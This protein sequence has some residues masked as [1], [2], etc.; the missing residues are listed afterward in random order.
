MRIANRFLLVGGLLATHA[1]GCS[2]ADDTLDA[3]ALD[4]T[5]SSLARPATTG[6]AP[7]QLIAWA[8]LPQETR[9][10]GPTSGQFIAAANGVT[11]PF[12]N[13]QPVPGWSGLLPNLDGTYT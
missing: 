10:P 2:A 1:A 9:T 7:H 12:L 6:P 13:T 4:S 8:A 5:E 3:E 11:P